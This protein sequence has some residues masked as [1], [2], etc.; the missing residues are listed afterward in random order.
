MPELKLDNSFNIKSDEYLRAY[1]N[2]CKR[3]I[4]LSIGNKNFIDEIKKCICDINQI[5]RIRARERNKA[6]ESKN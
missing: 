1:I 2:E 3:F 4:K 5:L 6:N